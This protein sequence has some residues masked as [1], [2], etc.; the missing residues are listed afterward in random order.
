[1]KEVI[2]YLERLRSNIESIARLRRDHKLLTDIVE[3]EGL[4]TPLRI[5]NCRVLNNKVSEV[6]VDE[7]FLNAL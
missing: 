7:Q 6:I 2:K 5:K 3:R 4:L 1:M